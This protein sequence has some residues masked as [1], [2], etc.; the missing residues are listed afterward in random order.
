MAEPTYRR[1]VASSAVDFVKGQKEAAI[2]SKIKRDKSV[3][4]VADKRLRLQDLQNEVQINP[5]KRKAELRRAI[6]DAK[7][8][9]EEAAVTEATFA[10]KVMQEESKQKTEHFKALEQEVIAGKKEELIDSEI[11]RNDRSPGSGGSN[12]QMKV[13]QWG[14]DYMTAQANY[15]AT[16]GWH[17]QVLAQQE[18]LRN[19]QN[20]IADTLNPDI[21]YGKGSRWITAVAAWADWAMPGS[22]FEDIAKEQSADKTMMQMNL[23]LIESS[24]KGYTDE[25]RNYMDKRHGNRTD[26]REAINHT[27]HMVASAALLQTLQ[28]QYI[29]ERTHLMPIAVATKQFD[30]LVGPGT[31]FAYTG[32]TSKGQ[33]VTFDYYYETK[34]RQ[35]K[36]DAEIFTMWNN[37]L[38]IKNPT[39]RK[40]LSYNRGRN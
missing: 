7:K 24:P 17:E 12:G 19:A 37:N 4:D 27:M 23:A 35:G 5:R 26:S 32:V 11:G 25:D 2:D 28:K 3:L 22:Q 31:D 16:N 29:L 14:L 20:I 10:A 15:R 8:A 6:A 13:N 1:G 40:R 30:A 21:S 39:N 34:K 9:E 36:T 33:P 18:K 38:S